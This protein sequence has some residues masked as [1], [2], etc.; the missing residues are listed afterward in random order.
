MAQDPRGSSKALDRHLGRQ[1][2][3]IGRDPV[4][5]EAK[6]LLVDRYGITR[7]QPFE[8]LRVA[9]M[10]SNRK[11]HHVARTLVDESRSSERLAN[12]G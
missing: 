6:T 10:R 11:V 7:A 2:A 8:I 12:P 9:S 5:E 3:L 4:I 1:A